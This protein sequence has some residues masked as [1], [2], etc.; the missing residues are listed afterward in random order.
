MECHRTVSSV[1]LVLVLVLLLRWP[2]LS[3]ASVPVSRTIT[4]DSKGGGDFRSIQSAVNL[5]PDGNREW[6][7]IHVRAGRYRFVFYILGSSACGKQ[8]WL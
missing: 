5:V 1:V 3:S 4:V 2:A 6:V 7:R 8:V